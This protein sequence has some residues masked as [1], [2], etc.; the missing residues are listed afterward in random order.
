IGG[1]EGGLVSAG[2]RANFDDG[3][4]IIERIARQEERQQL[5]LERSDPRGEPILFRARFRGKLGVVNENELARL[6]E[7]V[8]GFPKLGGQLLYRCEAAVLPSQLRK[9]PGVAP[10]GCGGELL[11]DLVE[12]GER[13]VQPFGD[14]QAGFP[15]FWRKRSTR[16]AVSMSFC[17]P[18]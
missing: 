6:R 11:L 10:T 12:S 7:L 1:E 4:A 17:L 5:S 13:G 8:L 14:A 3:R 15:Y 2:S 18:V 9:L 16:P